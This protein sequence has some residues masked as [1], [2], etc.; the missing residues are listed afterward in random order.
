MITIDWERLLIPV[1]ETPGTTEIWRCGTNEFLQICGEDVQMLWNVI[2]K[3]EIKWCIS[4]GGR[5]R[6]LSDFTTCTDLK[7]SFPN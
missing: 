2:T 7:E 1:G 4:A 5:G 3:K 6:R